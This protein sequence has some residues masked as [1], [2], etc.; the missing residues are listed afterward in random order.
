VAL[1]WLLGKAMAPSMP[2][3][4]ERSEALVSKMAHMTKVQ[5]ALVEE[6]QEAPT[7]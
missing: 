6:A 4:G 7:D 2:E 5:T 1:G 3:L